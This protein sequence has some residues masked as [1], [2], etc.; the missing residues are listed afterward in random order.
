MKC[1]YCGSLELPTARTCT[2]CT[3]AIDNSEETLSDFAG[4]WT[5]YHGKRISKAAF[6]VSYRCAN[7]R[8]MMRAYFQKR[9]LAPN[10]GVECPCCELPLMAR[11][12]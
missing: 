4:D 5:F 7:C 3:A 11:A 1:S 9:Q 2:R 10:S 8:V 12:D 6:Y